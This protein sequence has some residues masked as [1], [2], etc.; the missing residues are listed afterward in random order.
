MISY[1][2]NFEDVLLRRAFNQI[3]NG[4]Y[5]DVGA[6]D[7]VVDS[8]TK[9][10]YDI[11]WHGINIEPSDV[12][13]NK[14][15]AERPRDKNLEVGVANKNGYG[16]F[17][18]FGNGLSTFDEKVRMRHE[19]TTKYKAKEILVPLLSLNSILMS[20]QEQ[21][22]HFLKIDVEGYEQSVLESLDLSMWR[23]WI[24]IVESTEPLT[25]NVNDVFWESLIID[26]SYRK[27]YFDGLNNFYVAEEHIGLCEA[28]RVPPNVFDGMALSGKASHAWTVVIN[29]ECTSWKVKYESCND[30]LVERTGEVAKLNVECARWK[31]EYEISDDKVKERTAE[32]ARSIEEYAC[33]KAVNQAVKDELMER[34]GEVARSVEENTR[35]KVVYQIT[36]DDLKERTGEVARLNEECDRWES[37]YKIAEDRLKEN[38][39]EISR[40]NQDNQ[41]W[42]MEYEKVN[43][44]LALIYRSRSW[45][46]TEPLRKFAAMIRRI[47]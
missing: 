3:E 31:A 40:L 20:C 39:I 8:V 2:Q 13:Y 15:V 6:N 35:L 28:F 33:L 37:K 36:N 46:M 32:I 22:I 21:C 9:L 43:Q 27:T 29:E 44:Q 16:V 30:Q 26:N 11:G 5:I 41:N 18:D 38:G 34:T 23:P 25:N 42:K 14:L 12:F 4:F 24:I 1:A 7:P 19:N 45:T 10:F 47:I 17:Y